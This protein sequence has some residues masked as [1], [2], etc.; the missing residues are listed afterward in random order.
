MHLSLRVWRQKSASAP[1]RFETYEARHVSP[2]MSLL[3][4]LDGVNEDLIAS[5]GDPIAFD[6]DCRE[7]I[8]GACSVVIDGIPHGSRHGTTACQL[9]LRHF[10]DGATIT[11]E[12]WRARPFPLI[13]DLVVDRHAFDRIIEAGGY[14]SVKT[15]GAPDGNA[16]PI[17][18]T[19]VD[20]AMDA[21]VCIGCG[22]CVA[23]CKNASAM[24]FV[25]SKV[26]HLS[27]LPQGRVERERRVLAMVRAMDDAGFGGCTVTG[28]CEAVCPKN[29][30]IDVIARMNREYGRAL[31]KG[32]SPELAL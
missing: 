3:E 10:R 1:G 19:D 24:L 23:A 32:G 16:I 7:G 14:V 27:L 29:I 4:A 9:H 11:L 22:A 6:S 28:S 30:R 18:K 13:K 31:L 20:R 8:C 2:D 26:S 25:A 12:P 17:P 21:A 15:G 5:G